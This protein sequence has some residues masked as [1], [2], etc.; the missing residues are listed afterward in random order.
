VDRDRVLPPADGVRALVASYMDGRV[1]LGA[2]F[3][4]AT[5]RKSRG[6]LGML[7]WGWR[8]AGR[9]SGGGLG[10]FTYVAVNGPDVG[11][12]ELRWDP[13]RMHRVIG[14]WAL[15]R[16]DG[17]RIERDR[18]LITLDER[19]VEL[20]AAAPGADSDALI[21]RLVGEASDLDT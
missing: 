14:H 9:D 6:V 19:V 16:I 4:S 7:L 20:V 5:G 2:F 10:T 11:A 1:E 21:D 12:F 13:L 17:R 8:E 18:I 15:D 3:R